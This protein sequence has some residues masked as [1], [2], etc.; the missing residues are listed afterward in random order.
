VLAAK[1]SNRLG[2]LPGQDAGRIEAHIAS[3]G[4]PVRIAGLS[5]TNLLGH[6]AQDKKMRDG[7]LTFILL[8]AIG[9]AFTSRDVPPE[10]VRDIL[11]ENGAV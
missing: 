9:E 4:L 2:L 6:M 8:R 1:L 3:T 10:T 7:R 5:A 11:L